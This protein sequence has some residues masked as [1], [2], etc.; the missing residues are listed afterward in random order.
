V[1]SLVEKNGNAFVLDYG[2]A[3]GRLGTM[4]ADVTKVRQTL[5]NLLSN[6]AKFTEGGQVTLGV[7]TEMRD[8]RPW[9]LFRVSDSGIGMTDE[10]IEQVFKEFVQADASTTRKY[11]GTGLGLTISRRFCQMMGG[12]IT[13]ESQPGV[14]TTFTVFL[15]VNVAQTLDDAYA[16]VADVT[17]ASQVMLAASRVGVVLVVDDDPNVRE[18]VARSLIKEGFAVE[19][20]ANGEEALRKARTIRP[21]AMTLDVMMREM[22]GWTVLAS[23]KNDPELAEIPVIMLTIVD[24]RNK[25]F[26]LGAT[27]YLTKPIDRKRLVELISRYR[28]DTRDD[29]A[30]DEDPGGAGGHILVVEDYAPT[31][32][33]IV[34]TLEKEGWA[35]AEAENGLDAL[36]RMAERAPDLIL[37]DLMMPEMDGFQF[38]V[39]LRKR[40]D[41]ARI[42][43]VVVTA[44]D[45]TEAD[46]ARLNGYVEKVV[47]KDGALLDDLLGQI[48]K[49]VDRYVRQAEKTNGDHETR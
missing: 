49:L 48:H 46:R 44:K 20:A 30:G 33:M 8:A 37:L 26:A 17:T 13:V 39:E 1:Q 35:L 5:F 45:L 47:L 34:R 3:A 22:D 28:R 24:D 42:P 10:Q 11:G 12:D 25:G 41:W 15:P 16:P 31:R 6:A 7:A 14:G 40:P 32:E 27:D 36:A 19:T 18:L 21:D 9:M 38:I 23:L 43:V 4:H 2:G 29:E